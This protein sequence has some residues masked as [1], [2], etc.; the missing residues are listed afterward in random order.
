MGRRGGARCGY[1]VAAVASAEDENGI[2]YALRIRTDT[3]GTGI[4][5][6]EVKR[7]RD[8][9]TRTKAGDGEGRS[10]DVAGR[11]GLVTLLTHL[12]TPYAFPVPV[13]SC[14]YF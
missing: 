14:T 3:D 13:V 4:E 1:G 7:D 9:T 11:A 5:S 12:L 10:W 6:G 2:R 8:E